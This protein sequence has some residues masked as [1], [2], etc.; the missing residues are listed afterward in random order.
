MPNTDDYKCKCCGEDKVKP[1]TKEMV[2]RIE[3]RLGH[4]V[5]LSSGYRCPKHN[6]EEG[7]VVG[8]EHETGDGV[9]IIVHNNNERFNV[10][11]AA[12]REG[13]V[14]IEPNAGYEKCKC[15][16]CGK[17]LEFRPWVHVGVSK[18]KPQRVAF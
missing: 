6:K 12:V 14:R 1:E 2:E 18:E 15:P 7:G 5:Q 16:K 17:K 11:D 4:E 3:K 8:S 10:I 9:D 13:I